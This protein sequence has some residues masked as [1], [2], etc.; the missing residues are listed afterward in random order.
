MQ[1][2]GIILAG[3]SGTRFKGALP[4]QYCK[5]AGKEIIA[6]SIEAFRSAKLV[7]DFIVIAD[8]AAIK[9]GRIAA[10]YHV[11]TVQGGTTRNASLK[12]ALNYIHEHYPD[13]QKII[14]NNAAC[15]LVTAQQIDEMIRYLDDY[16]FVQSTYKITDAL[17]SFSSRTVDREDFFLIQSPDAYRFPLLYAHFKAEHPN[18][19][20]AVQLPNDARGYNFFCDGQ[21][22]KITYPHDIEV[23]EILYRHQTENK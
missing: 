9:E 2:I 8:E 3:G 5:M 17:G 15:P 10:T 7:D 12:N 22:F 16:D 23:G 19:H 21:P 1:T 4:K 11:Q 20:P 18:G 6:F 14:E 13:C